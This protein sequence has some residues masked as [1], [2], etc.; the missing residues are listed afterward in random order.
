MILKVQKV[1]N[2]KNLFLLLK[3]KQ[4]KGRETKEEKRNKK[5]KIEKNFMKRKKMR[6]KVTSK[7]SGN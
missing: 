1:D 7:E 4:K 6:K 3:T 5:R 2:R